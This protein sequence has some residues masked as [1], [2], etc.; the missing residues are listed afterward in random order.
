MRIS[1]GALACIAFKQ[2]FE[3]HR[4]HFILLVKSGLLVA[5]PLGQVLAGPFKCLVEVAKVAGV[6][7]AGLQ[8]RF[9]AGR[10]NLMAADA[11][12]KAVSS[13]RHV[14]VVTVAARGFSGVVCVLREV[15]TEIGMALI[16]RLVGFH[17][18]CNL[19]GG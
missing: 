5:I 14:T 11:L 12:E 4:D 10:V 9:D 1:H 16:A 13:V 8:L 7:P 2:H 17:V 19:A 3:H 6:G 15:V 18:R